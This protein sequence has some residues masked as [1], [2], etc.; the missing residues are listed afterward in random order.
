MISP[1]QLILAAT[2]LLSPPLSYPVVIKGHF[3]GESLADFLTSEHITQ[4]LAACHAKEPKN[5]SAYHLS[6]MSDTEIMQLQDELVSTGQAG[7]LS[8]KKLEKIAAG[9]G[10]LTQDQ[11]SEGE[12][13]YCETL[14]PFDEGTPTSFSWNNVFW[15]FGEGK[16]VY[17]S[18][19]FAPE[20]LQSVCA[21]LTHKLGVPPT[22]ED[23][24]MLNTFGATW[25]DQTASW[26][27]PSLHAYVRRYNNPAKQDL[28]LEVM[29]RSEWD[30]QVKRL[31][32]PAHPLDD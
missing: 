9:G 15:R 31:T 27:T 10:L 11:R 22:L 18:M 20:T 4:G 29:S 13:A 23:P 17:L 12:K 7:K 26:L 28:E 32:P 5:I 25:T 6:Q 3:L 2:V 8:R 19:H 16:L 24:E 14:K 21:D 30:A 1:I